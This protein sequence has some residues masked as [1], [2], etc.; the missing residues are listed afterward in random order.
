M[1]SLKA[2]IIIPTKNEPYIHEL[3]K[4]IHKELK[5]YDYEIIVVDLSDV[6]PRVK[7]AKLVKQMSEGLGKAVLEG[8]VYA[9]GDVIVLMDGDGSHRP[10]DV[11]R[12]LKKIDGHDIIIGSR[13]I[14][15]GKTKDKTHRKII[16]WIHRKFACFVLGL[17]IQD[18]MSGFS[19]IK[20]K[21]YDN[22]DLNPL[23]YKINLEIMYKAKKVGYKICEAPIVFEQRKSGKSKA[24]VKEAFRILRY[25]LEMKIGLR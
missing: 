19:A 3:I 18:S 7:N 17:N 9:G 8:L 23:G 1:V 10:K 16:S 22:L 14:L 12:M 2:S 13:F 25:V 21:V 15:G 11:S 4:G 24:R 5:E 20:K 6:T